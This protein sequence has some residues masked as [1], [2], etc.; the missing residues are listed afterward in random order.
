MALPHGGSGAAFVEGAIWS[1][2]AQCLVPSR[3]DAAGDD[4]RLNEG[5]WV[6]YLAAADT[7]LPQLLKE[8]SEA[9][10]KG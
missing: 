5:D 2:E 8:Q 4:R 1:F 9:V 10:K 7:K 6:C 3:S